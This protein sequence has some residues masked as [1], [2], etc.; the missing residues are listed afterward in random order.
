MKR[1]L[2]FVGDDYYPR[3]GF[4]D[5]RGVYDSIEDAQS[6]RFYEDE[7]GHVVDM[8]TLEIISRW[9]TVY[10]SGAVKKCWSEIKKPALIQGAGQ[11]A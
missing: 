9:E 6:Y 10:Q 7:W 3:G 1:Y 5:L 11:P 4:N 2:L 8:A